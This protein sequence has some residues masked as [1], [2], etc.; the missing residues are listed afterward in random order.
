MNARARLTAADRAAIADGLA[1][2]VSLAALARTLGRPTSTI[3]REVARNGGPLAYRAD[4]AARAARKRARRRRPME[5]RSAL[6]VGQRQYIDS[7]S[8]VMARTGI[9]LMTARVLTSLFTS[10]SGSLTASDLVARLRVSPASV[11]KAI[12][13][14]VELEL[15]RRERD[16][17]SR[18]ERYHVD[19]GVWLQAWSASA[20]KNAKWGDLFEQ[21]VTV[22]GA[23]TPAGR[24]LREM[25]RFFSQL[26]IDMTGAPAT[27]PPTIAAD[28][29]TVVAAIASF[30]QPVTTAGLRSKLGWP[31]RRVVEALRAA[32]AHPEW[33]D[34]VVVISSRPNSWTLGGHPARVTSSG[35][36]TMR[37]S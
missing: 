27:P 24:R 28:A 35:P 36:P 31:R 33:S 30:R 25:G 20:R 14:L 29:L 11:S 17:R 6:P 9:P 19:D 7:F 32:V 2:G 1:R 18:R 13:H 26:A 22:F 4:L 5:R 34:P 37:R 10:D 3:S 15:V 23:S 16:D 21:G 12:G 8:S